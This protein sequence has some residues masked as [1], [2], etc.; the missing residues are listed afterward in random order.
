MI[1][2]ALVYAGASLYGGGRTLSEL[3]DDKVRRTRLGQ[4]GAA[5]SRSAYDWKRIAETLA[6]WMAEMAV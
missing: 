1:V 3:L 2:D 6:T 5:I 4:N